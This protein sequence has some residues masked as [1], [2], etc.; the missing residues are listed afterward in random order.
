MDHG[1]PLWDFFLAYSSKD[2][3]LA[4][5]LYRELTRHHHRV[6]L[7]SKSL[8]PGDDWDRTL[9]KAQ[10]QSRVTVVLVSANTS[11]AYYQREEVAAAIAMARAEPD[12]HRVVPIYVGTTPDR[13]DVPYGLRLKH[14]IRLDSEQ[15][16]STIGVS[17]TYLL[18][19]L[20]PSTAA[21]LGPEIATADPRPSVASNDVGGQLAKK[22]T[23]RSLAA[24]AVLVAVCIGLA[25][26][27][28][29]VRQTVL[30][31]LF[32]EDAEVTLVL[33]RDSLRRGQFLQIQIK[34]T[35]RSLF[36]VNS[37][38]VRLHIDSAHLSLAPDVEHPVRISPVTGTILLPKP[39]V[40]FATSDKAV[41]S[42]VF[43]TLE[44]RFGTYR[45]AVSTVEIIDAPSDQPYL[46]GSGSQTINLTGSWHI[47]LGGLIGRMTIRQ[48]V[49]NNV[50]GTYVLDSLPESADLKV[51]GF[52]DGTSFKVFLDRDSTR[53]RRWRIDANFALN[54][55][56]RRF[57]EI[58]GCAFL[59][60]RDMTIT[61]DTVPT[62]VGSTLDCSMAR[63]YVGWKGL[64]ASTFGASAEMRQ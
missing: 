20:V 14:G 18:R 50:T 29:A 49:R 34:V 9:A 22:L 48:D 11:A 45:S 44:T 13:A 40:M 42:P 27:L 39:L 16:V 33:D 62:T 25:L 8:L 12:N 64:S 30:Q 46:E 17:L 51:E 38:L 54:P 6:F 52:K 41:G 24:F 10:R 28:P 53:T 31:R 5:A 37:G 2:T 19:A 32:P 59:L 21:E 43:A 35:Q 3:E 57:I 7:D 60:Q 23:F 56:D 61:E 26:L 4:E 47:E 36:P 58:K 63:S 55:A 15:D 1:A